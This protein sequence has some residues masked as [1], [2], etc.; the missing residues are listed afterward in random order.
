MAKPRTRVPLIVYFVITTLLLS[1][2]YFRTVYF[3][4]HIRNRVKVSTRSLIFKERKSYYS[5]RAQQQLLAQSV[6]C[7]T[8][9]K[10]LRLDALASTS[11]DDFETKFSPEVDTF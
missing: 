4:I 9:Q 8:R 6:D 5:K 11:C 2:L 3:G 10:S 1:N 7:R